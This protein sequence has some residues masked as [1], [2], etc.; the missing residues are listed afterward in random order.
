[1][2]D[3]TQL[4]PLLAQQVATDP[5]AAPE[6]KTLVND[7]ETSNKFLLLSIQPPAAQPVHTS[8]AYDTPDEPQPPQPPVQN[9]SNSF[10]HQYQKPHRHSDPPRAETAYDKA[11]RFDAEIQ[12]LERALTLAKLEYQKAITQAQKDMEKVIKKKVKTRKPRKSKNIKSR[13]KSGSRTSDNFD[14][15]T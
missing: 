9:Y 5:T 11:V 7:P 2:D 4:H 14:V 3:D 1:M 15:V 13:Y 8:L 12:R 10:T 6:Y